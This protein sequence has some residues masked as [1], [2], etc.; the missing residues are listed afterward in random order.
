MT[1]HFGWGDLKGLVELTTGIHA[2][3]TFESLA[4]ALQTAANTV[5]PAVNLGA[6]V[7]RFEGNGPYPYEEFFLLV[8]LITECRNE[9]TDSEEVAI[10][11][12]L[13]TIPGLRSNP[14]EDLLN[15]RGIKEQAL[16]Q[17]LATNLK[18]YIK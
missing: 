5:E 8:Y 1:V 15:E 2:G 9:F 14:F 3:M 18:S 16:F 10:T 4:A 13:K 12:V 6:Y 11:T 7:N 17:E